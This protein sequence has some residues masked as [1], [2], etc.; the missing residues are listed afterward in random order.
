[1]GDNIDLAIQYGNLKFNVGYWANLKNVYFSKYLYET[2]SE[3]S[4]DI[5]KRSETILMKI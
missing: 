3:E 4:L 5:V 2:E 1:M